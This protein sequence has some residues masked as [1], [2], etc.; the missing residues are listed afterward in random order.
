MSH[1]LCFRGALG[2][3]RA[4]PKPLTLEKSIYSQEK[5]SDLK[6]GYRRGKANVIIH[7]E[8]SK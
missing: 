5:I 6:V 7:V 8:Y 1:G 2:K 4:I 3:G